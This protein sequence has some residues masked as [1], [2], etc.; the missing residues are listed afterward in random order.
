MD[1]KANDHKEVCRFFGTKRGCK[2]GSSC[3]FAHVITSGKDHGHIIQQALAPK[4]DYE[5]AQRQFEKKKM[6]EQLFREKRDKLCEY[7]PHSRNFI[8]SACITLNGI[9]PQPLIKLCAGYI[10]EP[11]N[12]LNPLT[13]YSYGYTSRTMKL[14]ECSHCLKSCEVF[15]L[16]INLLQSSPASKKY[17]FWCHTI[18]NGCMPTTVAKVRKMGLESTQW[19]GYCYLNPNINCDGSV[20]YNISADDTLEPLNTIAMWRFMCVDNG[21]RFMLTKKKDCIDKN[22]DNRIV[23]PITNVFEQI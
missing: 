2:N 14:G 3:K 17:E 20:R 22:D 23:I 9:L 5:K 19:D 10:V 15:W 1:K 21:T 7:G 13:P 11:K 18:C 6:R 4:Y 8:T 16:S 12:I